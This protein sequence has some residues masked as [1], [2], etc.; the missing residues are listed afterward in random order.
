MDKR[1]RIRS[2]ELDP[3][4][5]FRT[6]DCGRACRSHVICLIRIVVARDCRAARSP[7]APAAPAG[8]TEVRTSS[9]SIER[10]IKAPICVRPA[11]AVIS[12]IAVERTTPTPIAGIAVERTTPTPIAGIP[13]ER[14]TPTPTL[15][16]IGV[17]RPTPARIGIR[18][19]PA[20]AGRPTAVRSTDQPH[21]LDGLLDLFDSN[22]Q[23]VRGHS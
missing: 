2:R 6:A 18:P 14:P 1:G 13:I 5:S 4:L 23:P 10:P 21:I 3:R 15:S 20:P 11:P 19:A 17:K 7:I 22:G 9:E 12:G 8:I 16:G